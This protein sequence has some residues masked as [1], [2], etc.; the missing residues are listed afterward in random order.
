MKKIEVKWSVSQDHGYVKLDIEDL[1]CD[2]EQEWN[3]L[4]ED[5]KKERIQAYLDNANEQ[6]YMVVDNFEEQ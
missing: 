5:A 1:N 4:H 6:P 2:S 3:E